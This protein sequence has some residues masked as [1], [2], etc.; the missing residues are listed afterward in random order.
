[1]SPAEEELF[2][3][4]SDGLKLLAEVQAEVEH[5]VSETPSRYEPAARFLQRELAAWAESTWGSQFRGASLKALASHCDRLAASTMT[6]SDGACSLAGMAQG[7]AAMHNFAVRRLMD[8]YQYDEHHA[9]EV[10]TWI[11]EDPP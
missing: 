6:C 3:R 1:M 10:L 4:S 7:V 8:R 9:I 11:L 5:L 2:W